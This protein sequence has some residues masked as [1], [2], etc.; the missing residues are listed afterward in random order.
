[1]N[2]P[3][4]QQ[5][6]QAERLQ[7]AGLCQSAKNTIKFVE[8]LNGDCEHTLS[9]PFNGHRT[10]M[11]I[12]PL[13]TFEEVF[14]ELKDILDSN[15]LIFQLYGNMAGLEDHHGKSLGDWEFSEFTP[16]TAAIEVL[17][18]LKREK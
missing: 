1:M 10:A 6:D 4:K 18:L 17:L 5:I 11:A 9:T 2:E 15:D 8:W 3:T 13:P 16:T 7:K 14:V 12:G